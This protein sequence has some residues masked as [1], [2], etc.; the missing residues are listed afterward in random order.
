MHRGVYLRGT[1]PIGFYGI[2]IYGSFILFQVFPFPNCL[3][4]K[5]VSGCKTV[6]FQLPLYGLLPNPAPR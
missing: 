2:F 3:S 4:A 1:L 6:N 5:I